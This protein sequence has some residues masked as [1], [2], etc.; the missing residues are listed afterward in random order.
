MHEGCYLSYT[1]ATSLHG[2]C[3]QK[4]QINPKC[5]IKEMHLF[6]RNQVPR[7]LYD[8][9]VKGEMSEDTFEWVKDHKEYISSLPGNSEGAFV[10][11]ETPA[12]T[13][14]EGGSTERRLD[15]LFDSVIDESNERISQHLVKLDNGRLFT[16][17]TPGEIE[18]QMIRFK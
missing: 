14:E 11:Y 12:I 10:S 2:L 8:K 15:A 6:I 13:S 3:L 17:K 16:L 5:F 4:G 9:V 7:W 1:D 18:L